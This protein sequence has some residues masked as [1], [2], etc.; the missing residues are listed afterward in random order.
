MGRF[1][2]C[3]PTAQESVFRRRA[4]LSMLRPGLV[5]SR[6]AQSNNGLLRLLCRRIGNRHS[7]LAFADEFPRRTAQFF[8]NQVAGLGRFYILRFVPLALSNISRA[9]RLGLSDADRG[10]GWSAADIHGRRA[11][12]LSPRK[13]DPSTQEAFLPRTDPPTGVRF[14]KLNLPLPCA[15]L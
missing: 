12:V 10:P 7:N 5:D 3:A 13:A 2:Q 8:L 11:F 9:A 1:D 14:S 4:F 15:N 6:L